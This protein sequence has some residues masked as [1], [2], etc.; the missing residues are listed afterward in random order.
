MEFAK[1]TERD[2][3][4]L[5]IKCRRLDARA[6]VVTEGDRHRKQGGAGFK[7]SEEI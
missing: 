4:C 6:A 2:L 5:F 3:E 1:M 7:N